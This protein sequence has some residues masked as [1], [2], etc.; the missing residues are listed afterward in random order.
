MRHTRRFL[1]AFLFAAVLAPGTALAESD[2]TD[3]IDNDGDLLVDCLDPSCDLQPC[4]DGLFCN[5]GETC[6]AATCTG[7]TAVT[8]DDGVACTID[9][10]NEATDACDNTPNDAACDDGAFCNGAETCNA[11]L[12]CQAGTPVNCDDGVACTIDACNEATDAC[13][14]TPNDAACDDGAFCNGAEICNATLGCQAG[15]PVSCDDGVACTVDACNEA[16]DACDNTPNNAVCDDGLFCNGAETCSAT[17]GCQV[18]TSVNCDDGVACT[19][20]ACNEATDA[21]DNTPNNAVCD[22]GLFCNGAEACNATLGCQ[23]G[24]S[25][26]CDD[27]VACTID[28][29]NEATDACDNTPNNAVCDDGLFCNGAEACNATLGCQVGTAVN[30]DDGVACTIDACNEATD[31]C[32]N[33]PSN[34]AC[35]DGQFCNGVESCNATLG[36]QAGTPVSCTDSVACTTDSCNESTDQCDNTP[37]NAVCNDGQFCNG[38]ETCNALLGCQLGTPVNCSDGVSCTVDS[39]DEI[40]DQCLNTTSNALCDDGLFCNGVETCNALIGCQAAALVNCNDSVGCTTDACNETTDT[41]THIANNAICDDGLF[42]NGPETCD[43][44]NDCQAGAPVNCGDAV[45]CTT[46]S[47]NETLDSCVNAPNNVACNDGFFCNGTEV[48]DALLGCQAGAA[49]TCNDGIVCTID[50]CN[51]VA[52]ACVNVPTNSLCNDGLFCNGAEVCSATAGCQAGATVACSDGIGCTVDACDEVADT[53]SHVPANSLCDNGLFCDGAETCDL[54]AGCLSGVPVT[55]NDAITCTIDGCDEAGRRCVN[56]PADV[57]C[58]DGVTCNGGETC[59][60]LLG[61][62]PGTGPACDDGIPCTVEICDDVNNICV[63]TPDD[64]LCDDTLFC[65]GVEICQVGVGCVA[66]TAIDCADAISCTVDTCNETT[67]L[68]ENTTDNTLC[69]NGLF[70]DGAEIC[71]PQFGCGSGPRV[72]CSGATVGCAVGFCNEILNVCSVTPNDALCDNGLFCDGR[73]R[74][75][76]GG[77]CNV[78]T[79][80]DCS[81]L[82]SSCG[83]GFCDE[84]A[85]ACDVVPMNEGLGCD[86]GDACTPDDACVAGICVAAGTT[87]GDGMLDVACGEECDPPAVEICDNL[88]DDDG[89]SLIDCEDS[90]CDA[91]SAPTCGATCNEV[92][93]CKVIAQDP[94]VI[95]LSPVG[96]DLLKLR[97]RVVVNPAL[98]NPVADGFRVLLSNDVAT[99][100]RGELLPGDLIFRQ[101]G[102]F[103]FRD[104]SAKDSPGLRNGLFLVAIKVKKLD[105]NWWYIFKVKAFNDFGAAVMP[106]MTLQIAGVDDVAS[107]TSIWT[108]QRS[109][110]HLLNF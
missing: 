24:T 1:L 10:C 22:D 87:C 95:R 25:V 20:D 3:G 64:T 36:C 92:S 35:S 99:I 41:C 62:Q 47:C 30:C 110:W 101:N 15:T 57:L 31:A 55:C 42:C 6:Q 58:S 45:A 54:F 46:D 7:G 83:T 29:C 50:A 71:D 74:C 16:T 73:E 67:D 53:C 93:A 69:D 28:A 52:N 12:G 5:T 65:N 27:G 33:T 102:R 17:L 44:I 4:D 9:A 80:I 104:R 51:T 26:N 105:A 100:Y 43:V 18:G 96:K 98:I 60:L 103:R 11:T 91:S 2:C 21:C 49:P 38:V 68:C 40:G 14:N 90:G 88:I 37:N 77:A 76:A 107:I 109:G 13:D 66:G 59:D 79:T 8:C 82:T 84:A 106:E 56:V 48:C 23:V 72:D 34:A 94:G 78:G 32:D 75:A 61:C 81:P 39:C 63:S 108:Q 89:D 19:N 86:D 85:N 97:G 70:C